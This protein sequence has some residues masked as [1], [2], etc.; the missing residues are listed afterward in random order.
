MNNYRITRLRTRAIAGAKNRSFQPF[1]KRPP[2][3]LQRLSYVPAAQLE[4]PVRFFLGQ[5]E[6]RRSVPVA[7]RSRVN[8]SSGGGNDCLYW[9]RHRAYHNDSGSPGKLSQYRVAE[10]RLHLRSQVPQLRV[11]PIGAI[12]EGAPLSNIDELSARESGHLL[13]RSPPQPRE[14]DSRL[15]NDACLPL[16]IQTV[17]P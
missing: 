3:R 2:H 15:R 7:R 12:Q 16:E 5:V 6:R 13:A 4:R 11:S 10:I 9:P 8:R 17:G 14:Q 1:S